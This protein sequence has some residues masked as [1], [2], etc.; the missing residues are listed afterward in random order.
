MQKAARKQR[1][2]RSP[3]STL[4]PECVFRG[5]FGGVF[6]FLAVRFRRRFSRRFRR[7]RTGRYFFNAICEIRVYTRTRTHTHTH[8]HTT[9]KRNTQTQR[10]RPACYIKHCYLLYTHPNTV[11]NTQRTT[12]AVRTSSGPR[13]SDHVGLEGGVSDTSVRRKYPRAITTTP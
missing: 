6:T 10:Q 11:H 8:T 5:V 3:R 12:T 9:H 13:D 4:Q 7:R 2:F 1:F